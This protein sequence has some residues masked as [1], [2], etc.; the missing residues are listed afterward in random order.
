MR[1][2]KL[3]DSFS[4]AHKMVVTI[5][6]KD[7]EFEK[8]NDKFEDALKTLKEITLHSH[9]MPAFGVSI[10]EY[11]RKDRQKGIWM[12]LVFDSPCKHEGMD[13]DSLLINV[14]ENAYG[15]NLI[16]KVNGKY[17]GRCFYLS[18]DNSTKPLYTL[19]NELGEKLSKE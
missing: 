12:E 15:F 10:D 18:L 9:E 1:F 8:G 14:T 13:F 7:Y 17:D 4:V 5:E 3:T 16:R 11:T 2:D 6:S 19:L